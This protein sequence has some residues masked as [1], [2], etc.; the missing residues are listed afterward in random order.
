MGVV[1]LSILGKQPQDPNLIQSSISH[2]NG[3]VGREFSLPILAEFAALG[4]RGG[5]T[6]EIINVPRSTQQNWE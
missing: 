4:D 5:E 1:C 2:K 6:E 3:N